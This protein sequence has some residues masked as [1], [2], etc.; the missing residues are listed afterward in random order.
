MEQNI[1]V[2]KIQNLPDD[3]QVAIRLSWCYGI[4]A[5][6]CRS[7][8]DEDTIKEIMNIISKSLELVYPK[9]VYRDPFW[10]IPRYTNMS[11]KDIKRIINVC[12]PNYFQCFPAKKD[13]IKSDEHQLVRKKS[14]K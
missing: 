2:E 13:L 9:G 1:D 10:Y 14:I 8:L 7:N 4:Q 6:V 12:G 3:Y 5:K 11:I